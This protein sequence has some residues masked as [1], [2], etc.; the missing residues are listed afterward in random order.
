[1]DALLI[2]YFAVAVGCAASV[3][4]ATREPETKPEHVRVLPPWLAN[5]TAHTE[6][7]DGYQDTLFFSDS[8]KDH[9]RSK[10]L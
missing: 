8:E 7:L 2:W 3:R 5:I 6:P 10:E 1:M 4:H 9:A